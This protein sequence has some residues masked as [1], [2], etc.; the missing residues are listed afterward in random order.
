MP[1]LINPNP[2]AQP[3]ALGTSGGLRHR[4]PPIP[5]GASFDVVLAPAGVGSAEQFGTLAVTAAVTQVLALVG[6]GSFERFGKISIATTVA[7]PPTPQPPAPSWAVQIPSTTGVGTE[8]NLGYQ[9]INMEEA[10]LL[11]LR[12]KLIESIFQ[13]LVQLLTGGLLPGSAGLQIANWASQVTETALNWIGAFLVAGITGPTALIELLKSLIPAAIPGYNG[14]ILPTLPNGVPSFIDN[15]NGTWSFIASGLP[16]NDVPSLIQQADGTI[17]TAAQAIQQAASGASAAGLGVGIG[18]A[19]ASGQKIVDHGIAAITGLPVAAAQ[20][21]E[22]YAAALGA[23]YADWV[24]NWTGSTVPS[25]ASPDVSAAAAAA[26][27]AQVV[28]AQEIAAIN[29][30]LPNFY[31]GSGTAGISAQVSL[32][33]TLPASFTVVSSIAAYTAL[34]NVASALTDQETTSGIW[35]SPI[36]AGGPARYLE[37]R[38]NAAVTTYLYAK[39]YATGTTFNP[40]FFVELGC[41]VAG[42]QT[43]FTTYNTPATGGGS[44]EA[45]HLI[46]ASSNNLI[47]LEAT[48]YN[49]QFNYPNAGANGQIGQSA[50]FNDAS[51]I[52]QL[53]PLYRNAAFGTDEVSPA[54]PGT[55]ASWAFYDSGPTAGPQSGFVATLEATT[56]TTYADLTTTTDQVTV[57]VGPSGMVLVFLYGN[58]QNNAVAF[59]Y[60][61]FAISGSNTLAAAD[62][63]AISLTIASGNPN[64]G[65]IGTPFLVPGLSPGATTF[66]AKYR[67]TAGTGTFADRRIAVIPL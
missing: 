30:Q 15:L 53:G 29:S 35:T 18:Q 33:G 1:N 23:S 11:A 10:V 54:P 32:S 34:Y 27:A 66:K 4:W 21:A 57:N 36:V 2:N 56:S 28:H 17:V 25:A 24:N 26:S 39:W 37:L 45:V 38:V 44:Q 3:F 16:G 46:S 7:P 65:R 59:S 64:A 62:N 8:P 9:W 12:N 41:L 49:I 63:Y 50:F 55:L 61:S 48:A 20:S 31:G 42:V 19:V 60:M 51:H 43:V 58:I 6:V 14:T 40:Q 5:S 13:V 47:S 52:S 22:Q 67:V